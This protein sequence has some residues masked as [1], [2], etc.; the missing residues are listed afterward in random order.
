MFTRPS[1][2][3]ISPAPWLNDCNGALKEKPEA[4]NADPHGSWMIVVRLVNTAEA[5]GLLDADQYQ[6]LLK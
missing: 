1:S 2:T 3:I 4:V 6:E 5:S